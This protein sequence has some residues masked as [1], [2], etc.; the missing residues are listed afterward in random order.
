MTRD[1]VEQIADAILYEGYLLYPYRPS[2]LKNRQRWNFGG[3]CPQS[4]SDAQAGTEPWRCHTECLAVAEGLAMLRVKLRFLH[5]IDRRCAQLLRE[6]E[7]VGESTD[8]DLAC[9]ESLEADGHVIGSWQEAAAR[10]VELPEVVIDPNIDRQITIPF[11]LPASRAIE[12]VR[13]AAGTRLGVLVRQQKRL[14]GAAHL[15]VSRLQGPLLKVR[16]EILNHTEFADA[17]EAS[18]DQAM[19]Y[20]LV[21]THAILKIRGGEFV[22]SLDPPEKYASFSA[23]CENRGT[24]PVLVGEETDRSTMLSSPVILYDYP[25]VAPESAGELFDGT[26][27]DEILTLRILAL[28]EEEKREMRQGDERARQILERI[29]AHPEHLGR[30]HGIVR[31]SGPD[32]GPDSEAA[33]ADTP[34]QEGERRE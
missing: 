9:V 23:A 26:E 34:V 31:G 15:A 20:S 25:K 22:S 12:P 6:T 5:L 1:A 4:Y 28:T 21:S 33:S 24:Y 29:E 3:L 13:D 2:A 17:A 14:L 18:R 8:A 16:L 19:L 27:I 30:L 11:A 7:D 10:E 32:A